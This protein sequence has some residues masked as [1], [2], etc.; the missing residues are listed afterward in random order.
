MVKGLIEG[1]YCQWNLFNLTLFGL[2]CTLYIKHFFAKRVVFVGL[3]TLLFYFS[4]QEFTL[5]TCNVLDKCDEVAQKVNCIVNV[6]EMNCDILAHVVTLVLQVVSVPLISDSLISRPIMKVSYLSFNI[7]ALKWW[8]L[9]FNPW[10]S[11]LF[12]LNFYPL[13]SCLA[14]S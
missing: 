2:T 12:N 9:P 6:V 14:T 5:C 3:C 4:A 13:L 10:R 7:K 1:L 8:Y 11:E